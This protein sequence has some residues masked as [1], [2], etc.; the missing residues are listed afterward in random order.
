M[1][2]TIMTD[3]APTHTIT[4][5]WSGAWLPD[6]S[7]PSCKCEFEIEIL[8]RCLISILLLFLRLSMH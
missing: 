7:L 8:K 1:F 3:L 4:C 6:N 5:D 2:E